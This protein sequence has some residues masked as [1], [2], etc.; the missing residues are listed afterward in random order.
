MQNTT[1]QS[2]PEGASHLTDWRRR[3]PKVELHFHLEGSIPLDALW[4]LIRKYGGDPDIPD[5]PVPLQN[6]STF[7]RNLD[8]EE[9]LSAGV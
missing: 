9:W 2:D 1:N 5:R 8:L 7:P 3:V 4:E 6:F